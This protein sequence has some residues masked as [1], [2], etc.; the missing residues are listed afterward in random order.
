MNFFFLEYIK[1]VLRTK[2]FRLF[3]LLII[4]IHLATLYLMLRL[5]TNDISLPHSA[6]E[7]NKISRTFIN[8]HLA[9]LNLGFV[10]F[11]IYEFIYATRSGLM[12]RFLVLG[13][14]RLELAWQIIAGL[15]FS[16]FL[17]AALEFLFL[18]VLSVALFNDFYVGTFIPVETIVKLTYSALFGLTIAALMK[19]YF[20]ILVYIIWGLVESLLQNVASVTAIENIVQYLPFESF[21]SIKKTSEPDLILFSVVISYFILM[22]IIFYNRITRSIYAN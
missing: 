22:L 7:V 8:Y 17:L 20:A 21:N 13:Y 9:Y 3:W 1:S 14:Q 18:N 2:R 12:N 4:P 16:V 10:I 11:I 5:N 6:A 15:S 19:N